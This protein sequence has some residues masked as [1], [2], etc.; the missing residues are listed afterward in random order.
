MSRFLDWLQSVA[1][2]LGAPGLFLVAFLDSSFLSLPEI[3]D[4]LLVLMVTQHPSRM[5]LYAI[6]ATLGSIAGCLTLYALGRKGGEAFVRKRFS[7]NRVD[8]GIAMFQRYGVLVILIPSLLPPPAP[9]KIFVLVAGVA[10][11]NVWRFVTAIAIGRGIRYFG[12]G[13]LAVMY[14]EP[15]L[16]Y[17]HQ[18]ARTVGLAIVGVLVVAVLGY[19]LWRRHRTK[20]ADRLIGTPAP[21]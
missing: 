3:N 18:N 12:E 4:L 17:I 19:T 20:K 6:C 7:S 11:I 9:F 13:A 10:G 5:P 14:G 21:E 1:L 16:D 2:M 15:A 8:R